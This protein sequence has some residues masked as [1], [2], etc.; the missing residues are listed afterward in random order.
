MMRRKR[1]ASS[2]IEI[3]TQGEPLMIPLI[4]G[5]AC[6]AG[7]MW[8]VNFASSNRTRPGD[9][10]QTQEEFMPEREE[11]LKKIAVWFLIQ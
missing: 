3:R 10:E 5:S 4:I 9:D 1:Q 2:L 8:F 7:C 6:I 11:L